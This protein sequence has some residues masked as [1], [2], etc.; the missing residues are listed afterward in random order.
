MKIL[1]IT[2]DRL[3]KFEAPSYHVVDFCNA[4]S[5]MGHHLTLIYRINCIY[6]FNHK[7]KIKINNGIVRVPI[8]CCSLRGFWRI[9]ILLLGLRILILCKKET[10]DAIY[11]RITP[12][13][14]LFKI[15]IMQQIPLV[16]ELNGQGLLYSPT[17]KRYAQYFKFICTDSLAT[18]QKA[19]QVWK[20]PKDKFYLGPNIGITTNK[21]K[22][23]INTADIEN[24]YGLKEKIFTIMHAS[25]FRKHH[26]FNTIIEALKGVGFKYRIIFW[27][28]GPLMSAVEKSCRNLKINAYFKGAIPQ[29][30]LFK[31]LNKADLCINALK[32]YSQRVG[33]LRAYKTYEYM[34]TGIPVIETIDPN[35]AIP[36]W[37]DKYLALVPY[38]NSF[39]MKEKIA[40]VYKN[41]EEWNKKS[42]LAKTW[43]FANMTW[44]QIA[45]DLIEEIKVRI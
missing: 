33:N 27:G 2:T 26:D 8:F 36:D 7:K 44:E 39:A 38:E 19:S 13:K 23:E 24:K 14:Y 32:S 15:L 12:S 30:E 16:F 11:L 5:K 20:I 43:V 10:F 18:I 4:I 9:F 3:D 42:K 21:F 22:K 37:A 34:A 45:G 31:V 1:Y 29:S 6:T 35:L 25:S 17:L 28:D 41:Q 40:E